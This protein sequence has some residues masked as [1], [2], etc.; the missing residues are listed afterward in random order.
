MKKR[1]ILILVGIG[2]LVGSIVL[3]QVLAGRS[4]EEG[5]ASQ[6]QI[7]QAKAV[8]TRTVDIQDVQAY[9]DI[10]GRLQ[11]EDKIE[12]FAEV[13]GVL[14]PTRT[15]FKVGNKFSKGELLLNINSSEVRQNLKAQRSE[16]V[17]TLASVIPDLEIDFPEASQE[18][19]KYLLKFDVEE[20]LPPLPKPDTDQIKLFLTARGIYA[21]YYNIRQLEER[22]DKYR[23]YAPFTGTLT[24]VNINQGT[25]VR[26]QQQLAT[27]IRDGV[28]ELETAVGVEELPFV[29]VGDTVSLSTIKGM[30]SYTGEIVRINEQVEQNT[31]TVK[32]FV[33][34]ADPELKAGMYLE[35]KIKGQKFQDAFELPRDILVSEGQIFILQDSTAQLRAI[36]TLKTSDSTAIV[37][38]LEDGMTVISENNLASFEGTK[39]VPESSLDQNL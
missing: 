22:L 7:A 3:G 4:S 16:F 19:S 39:V 30:R 9:I 12:I 28:Y 11:A 21:Q 6:Q 15:D 32:V 20:Q 36:T 13:S 1:Q 37:S 8:S 26:P 14:E 35:G 33:R 27:F 18:W 2:I 17:N 29:A 24:E 23:L 5:A 38:G 31:L 10:T 25:L 34:V